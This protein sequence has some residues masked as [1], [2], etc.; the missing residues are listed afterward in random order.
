MRP[1]PVLHGASRAED[2]VLAV[3]GGAA[4]EDAARSAG[5]SPA[6]L[7]EAVE[8]YQAAGRA[9]LDARP[10]GRRQVNIRFADYPGAER[11]FRA[12]L[13]P[14]LR[15]GPIGAWWFV[16]KYPLWRLR[17]YPGPEASPEDAVAHLAEALDSSV[18]WGVATE[19]QPLPYEPETVAFGGPTGMALAHE[20]FHTDSVGVL[21]YLRLA[22]DG[23]DKMLDAKATS[24]LAMTLM[25]R[26]AGLEF[27]EQGDVW[28]QVEARRPLADD[29]TPDQ[30]SGMVGTM[31]HLLLI[32]AGPLLTDG[33]LTPV[34]A[35]I[36]GLE[37]SGR[38]L[39]EAAGAGRLALGV[40][41]ILARHVF[42]HWNRM[43]FTT[44]QQSIWSRAA[45]EAVL[46][47]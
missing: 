38:A 28:G 19:W 1:K 46:G 47:R 8:R 32:E 27:G 15:T 29:V 25:M 42:F 39:A 5:T 7:A 36:E 24:L 41:G 44:R 18:S 43:G 21:E 30:V 14:A 4:I 22:A 23:S 34:R 3:L 16:R 26:A 17:V 45:R 2:A 13:M 37:R 12:Y 40:R 9:A 20:L 31:R 10:A 6:R 11:A 33:P 35:W